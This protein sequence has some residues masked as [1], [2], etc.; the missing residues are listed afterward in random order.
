MG[1]RGFEFDRVENPSTRSFCRRQK[2]VITRLAV[3]D[4]VLFAI[5]YIRLHAQRDA[6]LEG[7]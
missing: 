4:A 5:I 6:A 7:R 3:T 1:C 2:F